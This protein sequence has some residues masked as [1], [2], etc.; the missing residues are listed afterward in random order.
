MKTCRTNFPAPLG[1]FLVVL[2]LG[3]AVRAADVVDNWSFLEPG[4]V[5]KVTNFA[6]LGFPIYISGLKT[7]GVVDAESTPANPFESSTRALFVTP[8]PENAPLRIFTRPF[9]DE[10]P[11]KGFYEFTFR[12]V[13][14]GVGFNPEFFSGSWDPKATWHRTEMNEQFFGFAFIPGAPIIVGPLKQKLVTEDVKVLMTEEN[15]TFRVEW[16][17]SGENLEFQFLLNGKSLTAA[18][19][20]AVSLSVPQSKIEGTVLGFR[21]ASGSADS[22]CFTGFL[23]SIRAEALSL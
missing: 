3:G 22:P 13:E 11:A 7:G 18:N 20:T 6:P 9:P 8:G 4:V 15:Y 19:G 2:T 5:P 12:L 21:L 14:G 1:L 16:K 17:T 10:T 23:G